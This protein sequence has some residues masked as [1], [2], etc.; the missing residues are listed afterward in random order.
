MLN[1]SITALHK[2]II[3]SY[4]QINI[5]AN[6]MCTTMTLKLLITMQHNNGFVKLIKRRSLLYKNFAWQQL[7]NEYG[8]ECNFENISAWIYEF[9]DHLRS[10]SNIISKFKN[11]DYIIFL[12]LFENVITPYLRNCK[13]VISRNSFSIIK[14]TKTIA[15]IKD[16]FS[17]SYFPITYQLVNSERNYSATHW[18]K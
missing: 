8:N 2:K 9:F 16:A 14:Y 1:W 12:L 17:L 11:V 4:F 5:I 10:I 6:T 15:Q 18:I 13:I 3:F 7:L